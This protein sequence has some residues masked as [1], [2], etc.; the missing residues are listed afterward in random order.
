MGEWETA[1]GIACLTP[2]L[3]C[4]GFAFCPYIVAVV[5]L[6]HVLLSETDNDDEETDKVLEKSAWDVNKSLNAFFIMILLTVDRL[7]DVRSEYRY[8]DALLAFNYRDEVRQTAREVHNDVLLYSV[9]P[10]A[11]HWYLLPP[12]PTPNVPCD[13]LIIA[14][15]CRC[16]S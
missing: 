11:T 13:V 10:L 4:V 7:Y 15:S 6:T 14:C 2:P 3:A 1:Q 8:S 16:E 12:P 5:C 9:L